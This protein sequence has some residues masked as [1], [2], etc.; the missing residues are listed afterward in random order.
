MNDHAS[1]VGRFLMDAIRVN[2]TLLPVPGTNELICTWYK[3]RT[4]PKHL[5]SNTT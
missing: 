1:F 2:D 4:Y 3:A 5:H